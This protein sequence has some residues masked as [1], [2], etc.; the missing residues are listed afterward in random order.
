MRLQIGNNRLVAAVLAGAL[1]S[2][3]V[4]HTAF[5]G[6]DEQRASY[7]FHYFTDVDGVT[8]STHYANAGLTTDSNVAFAFQWGHD[9]V[10]FPGIDAAPGTQEAV[11]AITQAS[12]PITPGIDPY[13]DFVKVRDEI[14]GSVGYRGARAS[15]YMSTESDYFAQMVTVGYS[16]EFMGDN[17]TLSGGLSY[18]WDEIRPL[19][20]ADT[21]GTADF[22]RTVHGNLIATQ[23]VSPTT[24]VRLGAEVNR[25]NGLQHDPYRNVYVAG[26]NVPELHPAGRDRWDVFAHLSQYIN[27][28]SSVKLDYRYYSDDWGISSHTV[29]GKLSQY[30][31]KSFVVRY[32]YR[33][34]T[35]VPAYFFRDD[36]IQPGGIRGFQTG[37]YRLGDYGA[38]LL[39]AHV[40]WD[41]YRSLGNIGIFKRTQLVLSYEHYFNSNNFS[42][43]I[44]ETSLRVSF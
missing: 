11:D 25:V 38:H 19:E 4:S 20:D 31:G 35:Q 29:G 22:L 32:R 30:V 23:I 14:I 7:V 2:L 34:Y 39:G 21:P 15:Y 5:A 37:D 18:G 43:N 17:L 10:L 33:Y 40:S 26:T 6:V 13:E 42:A 24:V 8:V 9:N 41:P 12:R 1:L 44:Y 28:R 27:N 3:S 16:H 36:Y